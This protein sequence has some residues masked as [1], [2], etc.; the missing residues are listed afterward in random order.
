MSISIEWMWPCSFFRLFVVKDMV[1]STVER[2]EHRG[3]DP[4][5]IFGITVGSI[6]F[7]LI[8]IASVVLFVNHRR[9]QPT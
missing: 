7:V 3:M 1:D 6:L 5:V 4:R 8:L 2:T 9:Q